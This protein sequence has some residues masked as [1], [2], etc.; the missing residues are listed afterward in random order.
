[1][2]ALQVVLGVDVC[3]ARSQHFASVYVAFLSGPVQW[4]VVPVHARC[5]VTRVAIE[6]QAFDGPR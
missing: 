5:H 4:R 6:A 1:M 2:G 3:T